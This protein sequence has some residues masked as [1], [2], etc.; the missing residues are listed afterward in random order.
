MRQLWTGRALR[1]P[2]E[3]G[4]V[5]VHSRES[6]QPSIGISDSSTRTDEPPL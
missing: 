4:F 3:V 2:N 5:P 6:R 1:Y